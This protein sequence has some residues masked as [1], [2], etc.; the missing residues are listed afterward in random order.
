MRSQWQLPENTP[1]NVFMVSKQ[2]VQQT[3][4]FHNSHCYEVVAPI[5]KRKVN[6][7][8]SKYFY[9]LLNPREICFKM[10]KKNECIWWHKRTQIF[11]SSY[12]LF[13]IV[14]FFGFVSIFAR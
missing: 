13:V 12:D 6:Q 9:S 5:S 14:Y 4:R 11:K 3:K 10:N 8:K 2:L 7:S 1:N